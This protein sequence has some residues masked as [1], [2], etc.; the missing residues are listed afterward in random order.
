MLYFSKFI[1]LYFIL[2][3]YYVYFIII[4]SNCQKSCSI[5]NYKYQYP[6]ADCAHAQ[7]LQLSNGGY[8]DEMGLTHCCRV[9]VNILKVKTFVYLNTLGIKSYY[10]LFFPYMKV[11][12]ADTGLRLR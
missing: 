10:S 11:S 6:V 12:T 8:G 3:Q 4:C 5:Y 1:F 9:W 2:L 7:N